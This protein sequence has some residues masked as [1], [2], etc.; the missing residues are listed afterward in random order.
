MASN[1]RSVLSHRG[2]DEEFGEILCIVCRVLLGK[3][4]S[5]S[6]AMLCGNKVPL[7]N[8]DSVELPTMM[9]SFNC[10]YSKRKLP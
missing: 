2:D 5:C 8:R 9:S 7:S 6:F 3:Y 1:H 4:I 10:P